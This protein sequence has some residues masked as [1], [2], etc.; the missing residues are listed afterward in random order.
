MP[1]TT[2]DDI[3]F[4]D[5]DTPL[6]IEDISAASATSVQNAFARRQK[7]SFRWEGYAYWR[8]WLQCC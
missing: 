1:A 7:Q 3:F 4:A 5:G 2:P 8:Y 6:S